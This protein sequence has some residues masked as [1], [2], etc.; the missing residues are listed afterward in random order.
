MLHQH[1]QQVVLLW[2]EFYFLVAEL[3]DTADKID[4][5]VANPEYGPCTVGLKLVAQGG[6]NSGEKFVHS[7]RLGYVIV[8]AKIKCLDLAGFVTTAREHDNGDAVIARA[9]CAQQLVT[10]NIR[11]AE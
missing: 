11:Q 6:A 4:R 3:D 10:L 5:K 7:E 2:R 1:A 8:G 9:D